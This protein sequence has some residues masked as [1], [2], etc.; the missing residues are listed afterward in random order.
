MKRILLLA[1]LLFWWPSLSGAQKKTTWRAATP[2]ELE[3]FLPARAPVDKERIE[4]EMRTASGIINDRGQIIAS[5]VLI[6]AGYSAEGKYSHY[7]LI[8]RPLN[9]GGSVTLAAGAYVIGWTRGAD[10]LLV[11]IFEAATVK[12]LGTVLARPIPQP[13]RVESFRIWPPDDQNFIQIGRYMLSY[14]IGK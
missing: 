9:L 4:T 14:S 3:S 12:D 6:T 11:H 2:T 10:G 7:L 1:V 5:V 13:K 8:Q